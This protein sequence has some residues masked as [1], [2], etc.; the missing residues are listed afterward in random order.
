VSYCGGFYGQAHRGVAYPQG[1]T[2]ANLIGII[3]SLGHGWTEVACHP[4]IDVPASITSYAAERETELDVL[5]SD[6]VIAST[7][8][9]DVTLASFAELPAS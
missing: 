5:C 7:R 9:H 6:D 4:G 3:A 1:I 8:A 2:A